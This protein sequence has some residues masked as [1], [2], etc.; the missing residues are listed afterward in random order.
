LSETEETKLE[1]Y[2]FLEVRINLWYW[3]RRDL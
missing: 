2:C 1:K 3:L